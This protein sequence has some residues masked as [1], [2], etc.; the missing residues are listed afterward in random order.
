MLKTELAAL[1]QDFR[2][3]CKSRLRE[4]YDFIDYLYNQVISFNRL[5]KSLVWVL[6]LAQMR[7]QKQL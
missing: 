7:N 1:G 4:G 3:W 5:D 6:K 2:F